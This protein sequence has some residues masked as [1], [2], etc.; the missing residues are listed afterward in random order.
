MPTLTVSASNPHLFPAYPDGHAESELSED[1]EIEYLK[2]K[3][4][5][6]AD[7]IVTQLFYDVDN[8]LRWLQRIRARGSWI[9]PQER[10]GQYSP[11]A[12]RHSH[13]SY[14]GY[15]AHSDICIVSPPHKALWD[16]CP[17][18]TPYRSGVHQGIPLRS[19]YLF[20]GLELVLS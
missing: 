17:R 4:D 6:G 18:R 5:K 2:A 14:S 12:F 10:T 20:L 13:P 15:H 1:E 19:P 11:I 8:F 3:V 9:T 7:F 16:A